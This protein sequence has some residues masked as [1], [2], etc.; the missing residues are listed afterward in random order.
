MMINHVFFGESYSQTNSDVQN[1]DC[2]QSDFKREQGL[3][4]SAGCFRW[5]P[6]SAKRLQMNVA[7][8]YCK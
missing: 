5:I 3:D 8:L 7:G 2:C 1:L 4:L 6:D